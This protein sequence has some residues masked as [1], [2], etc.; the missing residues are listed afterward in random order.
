MQPTRASSSSSSST[1]V[2]RQKFIACNFFVVGKTNRTAGYTWG[3]VDFFKLLIGQVN[4]CW[5][6]FCPR[7]VT[8]IKRPTYSTYS[9]FN[10][11]STTK[12]REG[13]WGGVG[14]IYDVAWHGHGHGTLT[15]FN[16]RRRRLLRVNPS[17]YEQKVL[18][19]KCSAY[20]DPKPPNTRPFHLQ[21]NAWLPLLS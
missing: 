10:V 9:T 2:S 13:G 17:C 8:V 6:A 19:A 7:G 1:V 5:P 15:P 4:G 16:R 21:C 20:T 14:S 3:L 12:L 11:A 18:L